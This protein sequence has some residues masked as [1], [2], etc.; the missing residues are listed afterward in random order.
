MS[1]KRKAPETRELKSNGEDASASP[2]KRASA[3]GQTHTDNTLSER[4]GCESGAPQ[5]VV[6][7]SCNTDMIFYASRLPALGET[8]MGES[9]KTGFGGKGANQAVMV[10]QLCSAAEAQAGFVAMVGK[11]GQDD[12]GRNTAKNFEEKKVDPAFLYVCD[13]PRV[14]SGVA[15]IGVRTHTHT[16]AHTRIHTDVCACFHRMK[17]LFCMYVCLQPHTTLLSTHI[18]TRLTSPAGTTASP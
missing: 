4:K 17:C 18:L 12:Y 13:D 5:V 1:G 14:A 6:V 7:G 10:G 2:A 3:D 8:V 16:H 9:F 11:V 15:P